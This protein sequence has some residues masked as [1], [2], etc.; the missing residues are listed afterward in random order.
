MKK[1][2]L[3]AL[4]VGSLTL[5]S[6][7]KPVDG[8]VKRIAENLFSV[9]RGTVFN[10]CDRDLLNYAIQSTYQITDLELEKAGSAG[11]ELKQ[12]AGKAIMNRVWINLA[13]MYEHFVV[14]DLAANTEV[15]SYA[16]V[17]AVV[18]KYNN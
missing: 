8:G 7:T 2:I 18:N 14:W 11:I 6:F 3:P 17:I 1:F 13:I 5:F 4:I 10:E 16:K 15:E 9:E 12:T